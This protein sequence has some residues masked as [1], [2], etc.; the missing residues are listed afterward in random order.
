MLN[1]PCSDL[2]EKMLSIKCVLP[3]NSRSKSNR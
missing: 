3:E 2:A 1:A